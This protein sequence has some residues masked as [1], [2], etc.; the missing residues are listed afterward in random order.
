LALTSATWSAGTG[1]REES[2]A[3]PRE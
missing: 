3:T 2:E 1:R